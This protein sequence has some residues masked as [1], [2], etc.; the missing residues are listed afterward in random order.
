MGIPTPPL[1]AFGQKV[2]VRRKTWFKRGVAWSYPMQAA[3]AFGPASDMSMTSG[4]YYLLTEDGHWVRSTVVIAPNYWP[5]QA[6]DAEGQED[7][8]KDLGVLLDEEE[9][10]GHGYSSTRCSSPTT[11]WQTGGAGKCVTGQSTFP[12]RA[13]ERG[14]C[15][16]KMNS[17]ENC[18]ES[19]GELSEEPWIR[20]ALMQQ[21][22]LKRMIQEDMAQVQEGRLGHDEIGETKRAVEEGN[23]LEQR[24]QMTEEA[25]VRSMEAFV[26]RQVLQIRVVPLEEVRRDLQRWTPP[27]QKEYNSL[28]AGPVKVISRAE[29]ARRKEAGEVMETLPMKGVDG[30]TVQGQGQAGRMWELLH[31][32]AGE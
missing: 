11:S 31:H 9:K 16:Q 18:E 29:V 20:L 32:G 5:S 15:P 21:V 4:G 26:E 27:F 7:Q 13:P 19:G 1:L 14:E 6:A 25:R 30:K 2:M 12:S 22:A 23:I 24:L 10:T 28:V 8:K 17:Q 3:T